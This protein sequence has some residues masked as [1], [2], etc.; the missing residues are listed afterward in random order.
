MHALFS[1]GL[2]SSGLASR[3][4]LFPDSLDFSKDIDDYSHLSNTDAA[5][6]ALCIYFISPIGMTLAAVFFVI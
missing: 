6:F 4:L 2:K 5:M 3:V 1:T